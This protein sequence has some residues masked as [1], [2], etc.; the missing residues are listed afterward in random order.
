MKKTAIGIVV[1]CVLCGIGVTG[2]AIANSAVDGDEPAMMVSPS[3]IVLAKVSTLTVHTN[4]ALFAVDRDTIALD[5][6][7]P[8]GVFADSLGHLVAKFK[9]AELG[10][11]PGV[12]VL[13]LTGCFN[14]GQP[15][16]AEDT[17][18]VK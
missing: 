5:D 2:I 16:S 17:V 4:I 11:E 18:T 7:S 9:I 13:T 14:N 6:V 15:F 8:T 10:L 1:L 12:V 3:V